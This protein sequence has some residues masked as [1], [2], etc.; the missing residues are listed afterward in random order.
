MQII[1][2][3]LQIQS[4]LDWCIFR[5]H[6]ETKSQ[7]RGNDQLIVN[8]RSDD[9]PWMSNRLQKP[10]TAS[11]KHLFNILI[12]KRE[13]RINKP[14]TF[15]PISIV[16]LLVISIFHFCYRDYYCVLTDGHNYRGKVTRKR[17]HSLDIPL[18]PGKHINQNW[19]YCLAVLWATERK[20]QRIIATTKGVDNYNWR[21]GVCNEIA[22]CDK[23]LLVIALRT[24][25]FYFVDIY[26][27]LN[28]I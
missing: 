25:T 24:S 19:C 26:V 15:T 4:T 23:C 27:K 18:P 13:M 12:W 22:I 17:T 6:N 16:S 5:R 7:N 8:K 20:L 28:N 2:S 11:R 21:C 1:E 10:H 9:S 3:P 14:N